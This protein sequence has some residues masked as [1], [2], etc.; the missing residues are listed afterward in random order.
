MSS[1]QPSGSNSYLDQVVQQQQALE[2]NLKARRQK[3]PM[4]L[5]A[6]MGRAAAGHAGPAEPESPSGNAVDVRSTGFWRWK[7]VIVPPNAHV[8]HT[9]RGHAEP[10]H[11]GLGVS[12]PYDPATDAF[13][14]V[15]GAMQTILI[16]AKSSCRERQGVL[17]Q[18]YVQ[19]IVQDFATAYRKLDFSDLQEPMR[20]VNLQLKE[21]A[22][23][24][25][26]DKVATMSIDDVLADKQPIIE[27]LTTRLRS[28]AEGAGGSDKGLGLRIVTVQIKEAVVSSSRLWESLQ[29]PFRA[30]RARVAR[31]AEI[32]ADE[33]IASRELEATRARDT[34]QVQVD[35]ELATTRAAAEV[36]AF[37]RT[38]AERIRRARAAQESARALAGEQHT[39]TLA[40]LELQQARH[41][42][43]AHLATLQAESDAALERLKT[44]AAL[45]LD[46]ARAQH[47]FKQQELEVAATALRQRLENELSPA[48]LHARTLEALPGIVEKLPRPDELRAVSIG[49][50]TEGLG[51]TVAQVMAL[52]ATLREQGRPA[53]AVDR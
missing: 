38:E 3:A 8:V 15:P 16:N 27:E 39:T 7:T 10:L 30:E 18:G 46:L 53:V 6:P 43:E 21:Q 24:A 26:K 33:S 23:A 47:Q 48:A 5:A 42:K 32:E 37:D 9:R 49:G 36:E 17:V 52:L 13:L 35:R 19:W 12:F 41:A 29:K 20:L 14:V 22:E 44:E 11:L 45:L 2:Q 1:D 40:A 4:S 28:V 51:S 34:A 25:I 31:L 50:A